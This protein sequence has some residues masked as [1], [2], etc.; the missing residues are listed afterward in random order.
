MWF[1]TLFVMLLVVN[2]MS[3]VYTGGTVVRSVV[4]VAL[5]DLTNLSPATRR[6]LPSVQSHPHPSHSPIS[7]K[8]RCTAAVDYKEPSINS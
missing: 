7:R 1:G 4:G 5:T 2:G 6:A 8:R 3:S